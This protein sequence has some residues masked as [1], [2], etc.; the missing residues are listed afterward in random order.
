MSGPLLRLPLVA[1]GLVLAMLLSPAVVF[2][3][4]HDCPGGIEVSGNEVISW[5][6]GWQDLGLIGDESHRF[7]RVSFTDGHPQDRAYLRPT[8]SRDVNGQRIDAYTFS[9]VSPDGIWLVCH[10]R[11]TLHVLF[12][13]IEAESCAVTWSGR[14]DEPVESVVCR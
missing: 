5:Q 12:K 9:A 14:P 7:S 1:L 8:S 10:Y 2:A 3:E 13:P 11:Q 6:P 4:E